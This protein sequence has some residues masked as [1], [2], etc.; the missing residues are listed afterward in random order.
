MFLKTPFNIDNI[1]PSH[2]PIPIQ[3]Q[4]AEEAVTSGE[5]WLHSLQFRQTSVDFLSLA[6]QVK[7]QANWIC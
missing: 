1:D 6:D 3:L 4:P 5:P 2:Q 7:E